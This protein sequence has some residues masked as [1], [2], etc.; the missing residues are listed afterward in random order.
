M[1]AVP[2]YEEAQREGSFFF[3]TCNVEASPQ[4]RK[5]SEEA[6]C[7]VQQITNGTKLEDEVPIFA[8]NLM[9]EIFEVDGPAQ[10]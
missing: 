4:D 8:K 9:E 6:V 1:F 5:A 7:Q 10:L 3:L 2:G